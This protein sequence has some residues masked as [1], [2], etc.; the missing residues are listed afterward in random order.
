MRRRML[1]ILGVLAFFAAVIGVPL[2]IYLHKP[3]TC[4][5]GVRNQ[6]ETSPDHGGPC[7]LLDASS[8]TPHAVLWARAFR[9]RDGSYSAVAYIENPNSGAGVAKANYRMALYDSGNVLV[10]ERF[11]TTPIMPG[12]ITPVYEGN[13][14]TGNRIATHTI[15]CFV[16]DQQVCD[17]AGSTLVWERMKNVVSVVSITHDPIVDLDIMPRLNAKVI[18]T[19]VADIQDISFVAVIFDPAGNA[20]AV[21]ATALSRL[22]AGEQRTIV[23]TWPSPFSITVGRV[24]IIPV[25]APVVAPLARPQQ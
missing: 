17:Q 24:D 16:D 4:F 10:A 13:I 9:V 7:A 19:S 14:D 11:G 25:H 2:A 18:N 3:A 20:F 6:G 22:N 21:S 23:F 1:Y 12:G 5:D 8:I 15:F